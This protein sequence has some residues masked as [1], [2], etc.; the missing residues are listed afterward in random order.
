MSQSIYVDEGAFLS[1]GQVAR[2]LSISKAS[3][4][5]AIAKGQL[6]AVQLGPAGSY[7]VPAAAIPAYARRVAR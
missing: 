3:V 2:L 7:R 5:R 6:A 4:Y 1:P